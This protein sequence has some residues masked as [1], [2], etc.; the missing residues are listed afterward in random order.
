MFFPSNLP[1]IT[2]GPPPYS[3]F[4]FAVFIDKIGCYDCLKIYSL[5]KIRAPKADNMQRLKFSN[6]PRLATSFVSILLLA[7]LTN[8]TSAIETRRLRLYEG[9]QLPSDETAQIICTGERIR[10]NSVNGKKSPDGKGTFGNVR[11]EI[12]PGEYQLTVS[13]SGESIEMYYGADGRYRYNIYYRHDSLN[14]VDITMNAEAGH[15]YLV[16]ST[17]DYEKSRWRV[18]VRDNTASRTILKEG[19]YPLTKIRTGD[20]RQDR[21]RNQ[22]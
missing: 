9:Q 2:S 3:P 5:G 14:N 10:I 13:F 8:C 19:P 11:M 18:V 22:N 1:S 17:H 16:T 4:A 6:I 15:T 21:I 20:N 12:L 7:F